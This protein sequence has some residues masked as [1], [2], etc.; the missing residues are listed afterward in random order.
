MDFEIKLRNHITVVF[1]PEAGQEEIDMCLA[2]YPHKKLFPDMAYDKTKPRDEQK[3]ARTY[4]IATDNP[5]ETL[6]SFRREYVDILEY[7]D[8]PL[9]RKLIRPRGLK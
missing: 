3:M 5:E 1:R 8:P 7:A 6:T 9:V 2:R 4:F